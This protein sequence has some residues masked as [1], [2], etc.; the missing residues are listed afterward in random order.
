MV[1]DAV[2]AAWNMPGDA[3]DG[4]ECTVQLVQAPATP[5]H[6]SLVCYRVFLTRPDSEIGQDTFG[7]CDNFNYRILMDGTIMDS[8]MVDAWYSP[9]EDAKRWGGEQ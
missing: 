2:C 8:T 5:Q 6:E 9:A 3:L 1:T 4:W 7:G